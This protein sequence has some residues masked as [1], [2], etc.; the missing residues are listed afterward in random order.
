MMDIPEYIEVIEADLIP[1]FTLEPLVI[2]HGY[3]LVDSGNGFK[4]YKKVIR[5]FD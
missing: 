5:S 4:H 2:K 3:K 1:P